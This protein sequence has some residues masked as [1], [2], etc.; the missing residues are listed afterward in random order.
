M[1]PSVCTL[2]VNKA[3]ELVMDPLTRALPSEVWHAQPL[4]QTDPELALLGPASEYPVK[5]LQASQAGNGLIIEDTPLHYKGA[6][7]LVHAVHDTG[8]SRPL[9]SP[10]L[11]SL[12]TLTD[13][14]TPVNLNGIAGMT[15][16]TQEC[17][18]Q[19]GQHTITALVVP[20]LAFQVN[21]RSPR[22]HPQ[23]WSRRK[24]FAPYPDKQITV[25]LLISNSNPAL[26][27]DRISH[28]QN[29]S[30]HKSNINKGRLFVSGREREADSAPFPQPSPDMEPYLDTSDY[31][32]P[33]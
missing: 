12:G 25:Q 24:G 5:S 27:P 6:S 17:T 33:D 18:L 4:K 29:Y 30:L 11:S 23:E 21:R 13:L 2:H 1:Q 8:A 19:I 7:Y 28:T 16:A 20:D 9:C 15:L 14:E 3:A 10:A 22:N 32:T 26:L 31:E